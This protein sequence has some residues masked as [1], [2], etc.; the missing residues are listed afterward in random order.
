MSPGQ[1]FSLLTDDELATAYAWPSGAS[2]RLNMLLS[3]HGTTTGSDGTSHS[4]TSPMDRRVLRLVRAQATAIIVGAS[5]VRAEGWFLPPTGLLI[6]LSASGILPWETCPDR[7]RVLTCATLR[8][9]TDWLREH[10][11]M[12]LCEG[13]ISTA[14]ALESAVGFDEIALT[15][16]LR[17]DKALALVTDHPNDFALAH[18]ARDSQS[19]APG[20]EAFFLWRRAEPLKN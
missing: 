20:S 16:H 18:A 5:S 14:R 8:E 7:D 3:A 12:N 1:D 11:G 13:G 2:L 17:A 19:E 15:A 10:P 6:V 4:L 9:L